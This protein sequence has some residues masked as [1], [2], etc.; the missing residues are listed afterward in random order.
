MVSVWPQRHAPRAG[1]AIMEQVRTNAGLGADLA[2]TTDRDGWPAGSL[3]VVPMRGNALTLLVT[4]KAV[5]ACASVIPHSNC[6]S[7]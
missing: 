3:A 5:S 4:F 6:S 1:H 2:Q 7:N